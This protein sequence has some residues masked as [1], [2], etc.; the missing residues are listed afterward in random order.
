M[1]ESVP[2]A[3]P[4]AG[5]LIAIG[6]AL[7]VGLVFVHEMPGPR[8]PVP[9][10]FAQYYVAGMIIR[11]GELGT[12]HFTDLYTGLTSACFPENPFAQI[13]AEAGILDSSDHS[14]AP[15]GGRSTRSSLSSLPTGSFSR[16]TC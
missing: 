4:R 13:A 12:L 14:Y 16:S 6:L 11:R 7:L 1:T 9:K 2:P 10:D 5:A 15:R 3:A 8:A